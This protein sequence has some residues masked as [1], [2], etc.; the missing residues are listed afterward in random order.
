MKRWTCLLAI[1][2][3]C[4]GC[5]QEAPGEVA[6]S[7]DQLAAPLE[8][9]LKHYREVPKGRKHIYDAETGTFH[10]HFQSRGRGSMI[11]PS[12]F[13]LTKVNGRFDKPVVLRLTGVPLAYG[14]MGFPLCLTTGDHA[15]G[16]YEAH[17]KGHPVYFLDDREAILPEQRCDKSLFEVER[18]EDVVTIRFTEKGQAL[19]KPGV[20]I[21]FTVDTGW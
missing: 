7:D 14:C 1:M 12:A 13:K 2:M 17:H 11:D 5:G 6:Q 10:I 18:K 20:Q 16:Y 8:F 15:P 19:L 9:H 21:A 3:A 4:L